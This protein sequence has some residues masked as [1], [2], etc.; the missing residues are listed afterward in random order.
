MRPR[1]L[2]IASALLALGLGGA[3]L[4][5]VG[6]NRGSEAELRTQVELA[7]TGACGEALF[8]G[9]TSSG[10]IAVTVRID[11]RSRSLERSTV[12]KVELPD[13]L[14]LVEVLEGHD[15]GRN[16]CTDVVDA[17]AVPRSIERANVGRGEIVIEP[18]S[19]SGAGCA[20]VRG[21]LRLIG[22]AT[23]RIT[24]APIDIESTSVGCYA[25]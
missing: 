10:E 3:T 14:V 6:S 16:F 8:W 5:W 21:A 18:P 4:R 23:D 9:V 22:L 15:L 12:M 1:P 7:K 19:A 24:F 20:G 13:P 17:S 25:G 2:V 11:V